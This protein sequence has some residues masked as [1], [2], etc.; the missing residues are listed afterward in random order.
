M[1]GSRDAA[2][3]QSSMRSS[4][5]AE[6]L[7]SQQIRTYNYLTEW[8]YSGFLCVYWLITPANAFLALSLPLC[9]S[10]P[11]NAHMLTCYWIS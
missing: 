11:E 5:H 7:A 10:G 6:F 4:S 3:N 9:R 2:C 8:V 1:A